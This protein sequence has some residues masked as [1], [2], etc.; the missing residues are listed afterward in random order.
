[1]GDLDLGG[2]GFRKVPR[3]CMVNEGSTVRFVKQIQVVPGDK[4]YLG[5]DSLSR[6]GEEDTFTNENRLY[7][8]K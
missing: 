4:G 1:M 8:C 6:K 2:V 5:S 3:K 7:K